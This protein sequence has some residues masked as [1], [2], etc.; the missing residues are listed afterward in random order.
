MDIIVSFFRYLTRCLFFILGINKYKELRKENY[1]M[2]AFYLLVIIIILL[3]FFL[4]SFL[5]K[6][7]GKLIKKIVGGAI[8]IMF[9]ENNKEDEK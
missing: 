5:Y 9:E 2:F 4:L 1:E 7:I 3:L 6:P 8:D